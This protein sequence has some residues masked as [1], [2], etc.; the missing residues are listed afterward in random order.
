M[1]EYETLLYEVRDKVGL[2]TLNRPRLVNALNQTM[3]RELA[4][5]WEARRHDQEVRVIVFT[6]AGEKGFCSGLD[7]KEANKEIF[8]EESRRDL[9]LFY[10]SQVLLSRV[11]LAMRQVPQPIIA[12]VFGANMGGGMSLALAAD[13]R[14]ISPGTWFNAQ[15]INIGLSGTDVGSSYFLPRLIGSGRAYEFM[16]T[17]D[18]IDAETALNLGLVSR[19][20][21]RE[22]LLDE[23][24]EMAGRM[25][26][27]NP[28]GLRLTKEAINCNLDAAG[29]EQALNLEDRNQTLCF[30]TIRYEG[31]PTRVG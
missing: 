27:K 6:G 7:L 16:L 8:N 24:L 25:S 9:D 21:P 30:G 3:T 22:T 17:G 1:S 13:V 26:R 23:A 12:A 11:V 29:L 2:L 31:H 4:E 10:R 28:M 5:F 14:L 19:M 18:P 20:V 15:Y